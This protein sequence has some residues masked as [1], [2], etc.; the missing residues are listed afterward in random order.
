MLLKFQKMDSSLR[1]TLGKFRDAPPDRDIVLFFSVQI[2]DEL[3]GCSRR[4][5]SF[6]LQ[7][8]P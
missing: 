8:K 3:D 6:A 4:N 7:R 5:V 1:T 2:A